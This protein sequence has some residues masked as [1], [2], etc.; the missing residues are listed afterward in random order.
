MCHTEK[1]FLLTAWVPEEKIP[2]L[3]KLLEEFPCYLE[4][5]EPDPEEEPPVLLK[6][7]KL[8]EPFEVVTEMYSLPSPHGVDPNIA[9]AIFYFIFFGIMLSDAGYGLLLF[10]GGLFALKKMDLS[11]F[12]RK[13]VKLIT[14]G[15]VSTVFW[16]ALY[17]SWF[18]N[19]IPQF[20]LTFLG[21]QINV[22]LLLDPLNDPLT[23][24]GISFA[25]GALHLFCGMGYKAYLLIRR[26]H[27]WEALFDIGFWY[28][29][30]VG[31]PMLVLPGVFR[32]VGLSLAVVGAVGLILTQGR[33]K[34][35]IFARLL[36][37]V[38]SLYDITGYLS[39]LLSYSRILALGLATAVIGNVVNIMGTLAGGG[40][41]G[42]LL[43]IPVFLFGH[44]LNLSINALGSYVHS[45]R[46]QYV[47]FFGKFYEGGGKPFQ[48][49]QANTKYVV[50]TD[51][52]D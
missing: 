18:G 24:L 10:F 48:P 14:F 33:D 17:G 39:D 22:P 31:L 8:V 38:A 11:P 2:Q 3:E 7:H 43:F 45:S 4:V 36:S 27:P 26:G 49:L 37:G 16:G 25:L 13:M 20:T 23:I 12:L 6:N 40:I 19:L 44:A 46:L 21:R 35:N 30:L 28:M 42:L 41:L 5:A 51:K 47:E 9:V 15:G 29:V 52:E 32:T 50:V 34:K 1:T